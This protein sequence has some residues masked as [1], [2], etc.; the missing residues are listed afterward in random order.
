MLQPSLAG[1]VPN[2]G[3]PMNRVSNVGEGFLPKVAQ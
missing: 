3:N 1:T 2:K